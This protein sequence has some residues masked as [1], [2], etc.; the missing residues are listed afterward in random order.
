[1]SVLSKPEDAAVAFQSAWNAHDMTA[2]GN[3]FT[4]DATFVNRFGHY[5]RGVD[6]IIELHT[7]YPRDYI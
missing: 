5:V 7:A 1:M 3:L 6:E 2:L 4:E